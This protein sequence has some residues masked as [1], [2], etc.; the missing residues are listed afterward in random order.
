MSWWRATTNLERPHI[1]EARPADAESLGR[2]IADL[3]S[4][5]DGS[6]DDAARSAELGTLAAALLSE[7]R[8]FTALIAEDGE[9]RAVA[10]LTLCRCAALYAGGHFGEIAELYV[11][12]A[13]RSSGLGARMV[14]AAAA[15]ARARGWRRLE[16]GAPPL[17][18][19]QRS[20]DFYLGAGF[21]E[22]GPRLRLLLS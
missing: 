18:R 12:P 9:G 2:L 6:P 3:L 10:A 21:E 13:V 11:A 22:V 17:P 8:E 19:W 5:L 1:R 20:L 7:P 15:L 14:D 16:V 4:E